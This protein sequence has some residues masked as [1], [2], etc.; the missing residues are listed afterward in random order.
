MKETGKVLA[1]LT[2]LSISMLVPILMCLGVGIF[3]DDFFNTSPLC[4]IIF[5]V[6][7]VG[8]GFRSVYVLTCGFF[9]DKDSFY[10]YKKDKK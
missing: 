2:Q 6:I 4:L 10:D 8:A 3:L 7:G 9:K 5:V 1:L